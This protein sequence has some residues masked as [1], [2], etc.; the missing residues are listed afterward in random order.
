MK[1]IVVI[2]A[3]YESTR[4]PGK[5]LKLIGD[6]S[7]IQHV[8]ERAE[9]SK[10]ADKVIVATD[11][12]RIYDAVK[13]SGGFVEMTSSHHESGTERIIEV[14]EKYKADIFINVQG[15]EPFVNPKD[16]DKL[17]KAFKNKKADYFATLCYKSNYLEALQ[18]NK[19]KV[20][21]DCNQKALYFSR[22]VIPYTK[23]PESIEYHIHI[24]MYGY[25]YEALQ[26]LKNIEGSTLENAEKLEQLKFLQAGFQVYVEL[27]GENGPSVDT[28][29]CLEKARKYRESEKGLHSKNQLSSIKAVFLD[30]DGVLSPPSLMFSK[31]G[32]E[33]KTF[34]V[35]DGMGIKNLINAGF[36]LAVVS[37]RVSDPLKFRLKNLGVSECHFNVSDKGKK[38]KSLQK[39]YGLKKE[40][41]IYV[42]DDLNDL[43]AFNESGIACTVNDAPT[44][45]KSQA[46]ISLKANGGYGAI[47]ELSDILLSCSL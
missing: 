43:S 35:R 37:G 34:D 28:P 22:S 31:N 24:G 45:V 41:I 12:K 29:E 46:D 13:K 18:V 7:M 5:P 10:L 36:T 1:S 4:L 15:D 19:A 9:K 33:I 23:N 32:E 17:I 14:S 27:T 47:R 3:R 20:V 42:G 6:K 8:F 25:S 39:K 26:K 16:I 30:V 38:V 21:L 2:P 11:D 40:E 44:S